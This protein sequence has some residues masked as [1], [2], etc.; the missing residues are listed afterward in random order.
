MRSVP[1][2]DIGVSG[3]L[4]LD[5]QPD[6]VVFRRL[7]DWT[8]HQIPEVAYALMVTM[9]AGVRLEL[10]TDAAEIELDVMLTRLEVNGRS[11]RPAVFDAIVDGSVASSAASTEGTLILFDSFT[12]RVEF[13]T[14]G[15]TTIAFDLPPAAAPRSVE[16]WLP[17]GAVVELR[18]VRVSEGASVATPGGA[19]VRWIHHGSSISHCLEAERP[20]ETWPAIAARRAGVDLLNLGF[21]GECMLDQFVARTIR[22]ERADLISL[23]VGIN[24]VNGDTLRERTFTPALHGFLDTIRDGH[25]VTPIALVTPIVCPIA[26]DHPGPT[27]PTRQGPIRVVD[28]PRDLATGALTLR[29]TR[30]LI[31]DVVA[32]RHD[33]G[34]EHLHLVDGLGL[35]GPDDVAELP[36]GLHP[37]AEGYRRMGERFHTVV[38][39]GTGPFARFVQDPAGRR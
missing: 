3:A 18:D 35:F 12:E 38:F 2:D 7:P 20:I 17:H 31:A 30:E 14:G 15:P 26:E 32:A 39:E 34:E 23:K 22:D 37:S 1:L 29:R 10:V 21:A 8:R 5:R 11:A 25:P 28:R 16:V 6:G 19:R 4:G 36:D 13:R 33:Q 9:P 24:I 27:I